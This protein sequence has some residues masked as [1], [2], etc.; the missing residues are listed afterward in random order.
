M[1]YIIGSKA[2]WQIQTDPLGKHLGGLIAIVIFTYAFYG[3]FAFLREQVCTTICPYGR[4]QG[5]LLDQNSMVVAYDHVRGENRAKIKK[6][7]DRQ[8][9]QKG[10]CI[11]CFQ[12]VH[13]CP[14]GI[15]IRNGTQLE[16]INCTAC[17]DACDHMMTAVGQKKGLIRFVS[18]AGI[19]TRLPFQ[20]TRRV[21]AYTLLLLALLLTLTILIITRKDFQTTLIRQR[22]STYQMDETGHITNIYEVN[23]LNK[24]HHSFHIRFRLEKPVGDI[25]TVKE[26]LILKPESELKERLIIRY[27]RKYI[28]NGS[29]KIKVLIYGNGKKIQTIQTKFFGPIL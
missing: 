17:I 5:V 6:G 23:L 15:D 1:A 13:V 4:L 28:G 12:C 24:T 14:T 18:E 27:P 21:K 3:V 2:L 26:Q 29:K 11:D 7:E 20:W 19:K 10:D 16:C 8:Q 9:A 22:G 25:K